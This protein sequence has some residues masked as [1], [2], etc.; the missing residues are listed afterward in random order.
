[1]HYFRHTLYKCYISTLNNI[2]YWHF[3]KTSIVIIKHVWSMN[4]YST[5]GVGHPETNTPTP[6]LPHSIISKNTRYGFPLK[7]VFNK[8][9]TEHWNNRKYNLFHWTTL[10]HKILNYSTDI[11]ISK[12]LTIVAVLLVIRSGF[13]EDWQKFTFCQSKCLTQFFSNTK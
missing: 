4:I 13:Y 8:I 12:S 6:I 9:I 3:H 5:C 11:D 10:Y 7:C 1:M 2:N